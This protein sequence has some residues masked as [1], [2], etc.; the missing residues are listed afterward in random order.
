MTGEMWNKHQAAEYLNISAA[1]ANKR[2]ERLG[3]KVAEPRIERGRVVNY[4]RAADVRSAA[5]SA[6]GKGNRTPRRPRRAAPVDWSARQQSTEVRRWLRLHRVTGASVRSAELERVIRTEVTGA[7]PKHLAALLGGLN[8]TVTETDG[9]AVLVVRVDA[10]AP[11]VPALLVG[12]DGTVRDVELPNG[13]TAQR[14]RVDELVGGTARLHQITPVLVALE[15]ATTDEV[16]NMAAMESAATLSGKAWELYG[17][18]VFATSTATADSPI[19]PELH[20][21]LPVRPYEAGHVR[22]TAKY[23]RRRL[24]P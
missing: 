11:P 21:L 18:V 23:V 24:R 15:C 7:D 3:V 13:S 5:D 1:S 19:G 22:K 10:D 4:Y 6:P 17:P 16:G 14:R 8:G 9:G 2:L 20:S 12:M